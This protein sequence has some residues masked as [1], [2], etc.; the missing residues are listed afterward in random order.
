MTPDVFSQMALS[1]PQKS[2]YLA[3]YRQIH[4]SEQ[5]VCARTWYLNNQSLVKSRARAWDKANQP[6]KSAKERRRKYGVTNADFLEMLE[7]QAG[8]CALCC[9]PMKP[10]LGT[11]LDHCHKTGRVRALLCAR[12]N[13]FVGHIESPLTADALAYVRLHKDAK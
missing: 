12:C 8:L 10:G 2:A 13:K 1:G 7:L 5:K 4:K 11:H 3:S 6:K 9:E